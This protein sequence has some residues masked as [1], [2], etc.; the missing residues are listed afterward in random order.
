MYTY[1]VYVHLNANAFGADDMPLKMYMNYRQVYS[2]I[3]E[4]CRCEC[5]DILCIYMYMQV[6]YYVI[7]Y[8]YI[9]YI[10]K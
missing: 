1:I 10:C 7:L 8:I 6:I 2:I 9:Y 5:S 3:Y 4:L